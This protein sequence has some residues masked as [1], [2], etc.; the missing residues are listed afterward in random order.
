MFKN[1]SALN[2]SVKTEFVKVNYDE[3]QKE[4]LLIT[5]QIVSDFWIAPKVVLFSEFGDPDKIF[6]IHHVST[7]PKEKSP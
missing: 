6:D 3:M 5:S 4:E 2:Q 7:D 1:V